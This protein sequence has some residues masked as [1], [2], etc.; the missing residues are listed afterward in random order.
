MNT[1]TNLDFSKKRIGLALSGGGMRAAVFHLGVLKYLARVGLYD[2][3]TAISSVSGASLCIGAILAAN[4]NKWCSGR[5]FLD[6]TLPA[7]REKM[8]GSDI[9][10]SA[11]R[12]LPFSAKYWFNRVWGIS[13][14][15]TRKTRSCLY[16]I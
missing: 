13:K 4:S 7:V 9:Q 10:K 11:L 12:R 16:P 6:S 2:S 8:L 5:V 15:A 1:I 3:I 14:S